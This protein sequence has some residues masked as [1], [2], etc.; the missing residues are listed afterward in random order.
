MLLENTGAKVD[1]MADSARA[2]TL[3][4]SQPLAGLLGRKSAC[5]LLIRP[6]LF[7]G[8][9]R[10]SS[11]SQEVAMGEIIAEDDGL[12]CSEVGAWAE[13]KYTLVG[14]YDRLFSKIGSAS[15]RARV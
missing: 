13:D 15:C 2:T 9:S 5:S 7:A 4:T 10:K 12:P 6:L 11:T 14:L 1:S 3:A 8:R